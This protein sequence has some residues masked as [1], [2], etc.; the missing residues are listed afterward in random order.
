MLFSQRQTINDVITGII[1]CGTRLYMQE[2]SHNSSKAQS[3]A[4]VLLSTRTVSG[5]KL[6][7]EMVK[8][9][10]D[11]PWGEQ[12]QLLAYTNTKVYRS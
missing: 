1:F 3:I 10:S 6:V 5:Y 7:Q 12:I 11:A 2:I 9:G 8:P 4:V